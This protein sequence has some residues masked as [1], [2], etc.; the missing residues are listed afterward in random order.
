MS[1]PFEREKF[2]AISCVH[3]FSH[4]IENDRLKVAEELSRVLKKEGHVLVEVFGRNDLR[5]GEGEQIEKA[6]F[7][8]GNGI[9]THYFQEGEV[10]R[11][12][13]KLSPMSE[14]TQVRRI[15]LG[16]IAGKREILRILLRKNR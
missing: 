7:L 8:R 16:T 6:T 3:A 11:M 5:Y 2:D 12:F 4:V 14:V 13:S 10:A 9:Q 15:T 1:L